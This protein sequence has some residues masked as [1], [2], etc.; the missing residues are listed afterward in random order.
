MCFLFGALATLFTLYSR[1]FEDVRVHRN[2]VALIAVFLFLAGLLFIT[3]GLLAE[4]VTRTYF[5]SQGKST[6]V[7]RSIVGRGLKGRRTLSH[8]ANGTAHSTRFV[9]FGKAGGR[10]PKAPPESDR[11]LAGAGSGAGR[12]SSPAPWRRIARRHRSASLGAP[13]RRSPLTQMRSRSA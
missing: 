2:P 4:L 13:A 9:K 3:Q 8:S 6:Y 11:P 10:V 1:L 7:I 12:G 5:E